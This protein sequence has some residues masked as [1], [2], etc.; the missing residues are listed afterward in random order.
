MDTNKNEEIHQLWDELCDIGLHEIDQALTHCMRRLCN[1][2]GAQN[3][4]WVGTVRMNQDADMRT[5]IMCGWRIRSVHYMDNTYYDPVLV[6][7]SMQEKMTE[8]PG[9]TNIALAANAG[10]FRSYRLHGGELVDVKEFK[11]T[12]HYDM[13]YT[14]LDVNDRMWVAFPVSSDTESV[15]C[16]DRHGDQKQFADSDLEVV[17]YALRGIKWFHRQLLLSHGLGI[18]EEPITAAEHRVKKGLLVGATEKEIAKQLNLSPGTV[19]QYAMRIY[20]KFGVQG[21]AEF[22]SL[23]LSGGGIKS[24]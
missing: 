19:H 18:C 11:K 12:A 15:F 24:Q 2:V 8:D 14:H 7:H 5:D 22:M 21:R 16:F 6:R 1:L 3:A 13:Y 17:S 9:A 10:R 4:F 20:R 23:W